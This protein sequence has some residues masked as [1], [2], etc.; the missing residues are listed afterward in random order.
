MWEQ[1][2]RVAEKAA[3]R[4]GKILEERFGKVKEIARKGEIDLVTE[5][6]LMSERAILGIIGDSFPKD[7][8]LAEESGEYG[9]N[10]D[11]LWIIDPLDGTTN[12]AHS[13]PFYAISI[14]FQAHGELVLGLVYN[15]CLNEYFEARKGEG[16]FLNKKTIRVSQSKT[17]RESLLATGFPYSVYREPDGVMALLKKM[18][19]FAQG[20]R[21]PGAAA[22]DMC[23][24]ASGRLDG[25]WEEGLKA[26]DTAAGSL[27]VAE[28]G[29]KV[30]DY[31]GEPY[32]PFQKSIVAANPFIH[33]K[34]LDVLKT[35]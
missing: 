12:F 11:R 6:D 16:A 25:F 17:L 5:A 31:R 8:I 1:E 20:I 22:I 28:A 18:I 3:K 14:A 4:A 23:Y 15:P 13:F 19:V 29:G 35:A 9:Q 24:V 2:T 34:M 7:A 33:R 32:S 27:I 26:W 30:S 21:R 10:P